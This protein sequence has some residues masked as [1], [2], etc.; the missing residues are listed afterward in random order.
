VPASS[1]LIV[2]IDPEATDRL[3]KALSAA[4]HSVTLAATAD[5]AL[6]AAVAQQLVIMDSV[7]DGDGIAGVCRSI[8]STPALA[9]IPILCFAE[10]NDVESRVRLLE[11]GADDVVGKPFDARE[12]E[13][14]VDA[15]LVRLELSGGRTPT[16][17]A[18][19]VLRP[20]QVVACFSPKGGV[21]TT[22]IAVNL[23]VLLAERRPD[24]VALVDLAIPIGQVTTHLDLKPRHT[25]DELA[26]DSMAL[27]D[28]ALVR[29]T[30]ERYQ[31]QLD[32]YALPVDPTDADQLGVKEVE[33]LLTAIRDIYPIVV[34]DAGA[35]IG[36]RSLA[37]SEA[38]DRVVLTTT[39]EIPSLKAV[40]AF[41]RMMAERG[42]ANRAVFVVNHLYAREMVRSSDIEQQFGARVALELP[43]DPL[44][45]VKAVNEGIPVVRGATRSAPAER[46]AELASIV[47]GDLP[48]EVER[49]PPRRGLFGGVKRN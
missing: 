22:T 26:R 34:V 3:S 36:P 38:A 4:G 21:G 49:R 44:I 7:Q 24:E 29:A 15:L 13:A 12:V 11:A 33:L 40:G 9:P 17:A 14:R 16:V 8:R 28:P 32:V 46:L 2:S 1:V 23:A 18:E 25:L 20:H 10:G 45:Y 5:E 30:A 19:P 43:Y 41:M 27:S 37:I 47:A 39:A 42:L 6:K 48:A 35:T 31:G